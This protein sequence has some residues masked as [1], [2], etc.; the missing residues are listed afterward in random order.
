MPSM[1]GVRHLLEIVA[2]LEGAGLAFVGVDREI[3]RGGMAT[4][5]APLAP[6]GKAGAAEPAQA[7]GEERRLDLLR[8]AR[9]RA[10]PAERDVAA[11]GGIGGVV[12]VAGDDRVDAAVGDRRLDRGGGGAL[13]VEMPDL[14]HRRH[15]AAAHAG[16][17]DHADPGRI[18]AGGERRAQRLGSG[19][20]AGQRVADPD[21]DRRAAGSHPPSPRRN[22]RR[23]WRPP[24]P[25]PATGASPRPARADARA[26]AA[27]RVLDQVEKLDQ[28]VAAAR[29]V[30]EEPAHLGERVVVERPAPWAGRARGPCRTSRCPC[31]RPSRFPSRS[32]DHSAGGRP[33]QPKTPM[34]RAGTAGG[35]RAMLTALSLD[36]APHA[37]DHRRPRGHRPSRAAGRVAVAGGADRARRR[38][39][40]GGMDGDGDGAHA[41][42]SH[43]RRRSGRSSTTIPA[44]TG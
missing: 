16:R 10:E 6:G 29:P 21:G 42:L 38:H 13:D 37:P 23:R 19:E 9:A 3:A 4:H 28:Q 8:R 30:A 35:P 40:G 14:G 41:H 5:R 15:V 22:G 31:A 12:L 32:R 43:Q 33:P 2:V 39:P 27:V 7:G 36:G 24:R 34:L 17:G 44:P 1:N 20:R 26:E 25:R 18:E 11:A